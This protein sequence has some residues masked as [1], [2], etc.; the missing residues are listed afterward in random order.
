MKTHQQIIEDGWLEILANME[1]STND[2]DERQRRIN[3][4]M[5]A[6][7]NGNEVRGTVNGKAVVLNK[8]YNAGVS[9]A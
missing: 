6:L 7:R 9:G 8:Q 5:D 2:Q 3:V 1:M 4:A